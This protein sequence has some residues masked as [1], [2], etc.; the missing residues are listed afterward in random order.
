MNQII[1]NYDYNYNKVNK[2]IRN[3]KNIYFIIFIITTI[4]IVIIFFYIIYNKYKL[5]QEARLSENFKNAYII[6]TLYSNSQNS[7]N[8]NAIQLSNSISIIG[9]IEIPQINISYPILSQ[10]NDELL[11]ISV[12]RFSRSITQSK[13]KFV[14]YWT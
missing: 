11:K 4:V 8:Y 7:T 5:M 13:G 14:Y 2:Y 3:K 10:S 9:L 6:S 12:C 1:F